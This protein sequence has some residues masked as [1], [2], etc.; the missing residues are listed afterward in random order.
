MLA[1]AMRH[2]ANRYAAASGQSVAVF[3]NND[4]GTAR[5]GT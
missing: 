2:F 5:R 4:P 1:S 3:T